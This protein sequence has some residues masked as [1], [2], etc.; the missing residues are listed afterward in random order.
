MAS[1]EKLPSP[2][3]KSTKEAA[4]L[5][6]QNYGK[7]ESLKGRGVSDADL[8]GKVPT[9]NMMIFHRYFLFL[10][11][12]MFGSCRI[13]YCQISSIGLLIP[14]D[15]LNM[16]SQCKH[17]IALI[18]MILFLLSQHLTKCIHNMAI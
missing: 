9:L 12:S 11:S 7:V 15:Y 17:Y 3:G 13:T 18:S 16:F 2:A 6:L 10:S 8:A 1:W 4:P 14:I 5:K